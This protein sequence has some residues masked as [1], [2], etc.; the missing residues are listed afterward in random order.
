MVCYVTIT[1]GNFQCITQITRNYGLAN[2]HGPRLVL[3]TTPLVCAIKMSLYYENT[4][5]RCDL[6]ISTVRQ[7]LVSVWFRWM[8]LC[9]GVECSTEILCFYTTDLAYFIWMLVLSYTMDKEISC[10]YSCSF[11]I[12][13]LHWDGLHEVDAITW[14]ETFPYKSLLAGCNKKCDQTQYFPIILCCACFLHSND[15]IQCYRNCDFCPIFC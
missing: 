8:Y 2:H 11:S 7:Q 15:P 13:W 10:S 14:I 5:L 12:P 3:C 6:G 4:Q 9:F 1:A